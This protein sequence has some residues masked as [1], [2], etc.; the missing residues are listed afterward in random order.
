MKA[1]F[2]SLL[3]AKTSKK[4]KTIGK[5]ESETPVATAGIAIKEKNN[6]KAMPLLHRQVKNQ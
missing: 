6:N 1:V 4:K 2:F 3:W 5:K